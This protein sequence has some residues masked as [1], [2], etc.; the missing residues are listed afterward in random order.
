MT[1]GEVKRIGGKLGFSFTEL[2]AKKA[3]LIERIVSREIKNVAR[4]AKAKV[5]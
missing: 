4:A 1:Y 3:I 2:H 5:T